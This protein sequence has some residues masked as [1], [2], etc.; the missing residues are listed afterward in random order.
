MSELDAIQN[1]IQD[2]NLSYLLVAQRLL[3]ANFDAGRVNLGFDESTAHQLLQM[4]HRQLKNLASRTNFI[5]SMREASTK[6]LASLSRDD[7]DGVLQRT[8]AAMVFSRHPGLVLG[9]P[10]PQ[11]LAL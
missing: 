7:V 1:D 11:K 5:V 3:T 10:S 4:T 8:R 6:A 9:D 2:V